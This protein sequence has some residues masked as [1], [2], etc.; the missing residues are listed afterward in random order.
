MPAEQEGEPKGCAVREGRAGGLAGGGFGP[1][2]RTWAR[3]AAA[4]DRTTGSGAGTQRAGADHNYLL[5]PRLTTSA[6]RIT[7]SARRRR[8]VSMRA[9]S[10][11]PERGKKRA[12]RMR[13]KNSSGR[14]VGAAA[15]QVSERSGASRGAGL[16]ALAGSA[17]CRGNRRSPVIGGVASC[18]RG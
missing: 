6:R 17:R 13:K 5:P 8:P 18:G 15:N 4:F 7:T 14:G 1:S 2:L 11:A 16:K 10:L 3:Q 9:L 12:L